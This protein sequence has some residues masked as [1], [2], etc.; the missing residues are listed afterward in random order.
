M[1]SNSDSAIPRGMQTERQTSADL[2]NGA[3]CTQFGMP[4][5]IFTPDLH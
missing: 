4:L 3:A 2:A 1:E 5:K